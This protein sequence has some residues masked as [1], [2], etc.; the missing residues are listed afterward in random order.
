MV[1]RFGQISSDEDDI[2]VKCGRVLSKLCSCDTGGHDEVDVD[3]DDDVHRLDA[4]DIHE[5]DDEDG[6]L[7]DDVDDAAEADGAISR[8]NITTTSATSSTTAPG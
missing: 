7:G 8:S 5:H 6:A 1:F 4:D 3:G 2:E